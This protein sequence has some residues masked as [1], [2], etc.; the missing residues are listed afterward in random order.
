MGELYRLAGLVPLMV[1]ARVAALFDNEVID[2]LVDGLAGGV[3]EVGRRLRFAQRGQMQQNLAFAF[4]AAALLFL[5]F[6]WYSNV[7]A[8]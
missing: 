1:S 8:R 6:L 5:A 2:G 7:F 4:G 3:R